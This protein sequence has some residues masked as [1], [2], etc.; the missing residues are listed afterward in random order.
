MKLE[1]VK[2]TDYVHDFY[3]TYVAADAVWKMTQAVDSTGKVGAIALLLDSG[4]G[5]SIIALMIQLYELA[6]NLKENDDST[7]I[8]TTQESFIYPM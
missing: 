8:V 4:S 3:Q 5:K 7:F 1:K 6:H 2:N